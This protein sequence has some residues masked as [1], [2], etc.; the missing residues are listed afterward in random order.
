MRDRFIISESDRQSILSMY[1]LLTEEERDYTF[2]GRILG[3]DGDYSIGARVSIVGE[4]KEFV[5]G[6]TTD[7]NGSY[8]LNVKL[9]NTKI[10]YII[11]KATKETDIEEKIVNMD[12]FVQTINLNFVKSKQREEVKVTTTRSVR[13]L[14]NVKDTEGNEITDYNL[15]VKSKGQEIFKA[16]VKEKNQELVFL[17]GGTEINTKP[18]NYEEIKK[19]NDLIEINNSGKIE[20]LIQ[21]SG[22]VPSDKKIKYDGY[23]CNINMGSK[24]DES[25]NH[26]FVKTDGY[27]VNIIPNKKQNDINIVI[28]KIQTSIELTLIDQFKEIVST[29]NVNIKSKDGSINETLTTDTNG[30]LI[31]DANNWPSNTDYFIVA[32]KEGYQKQFYNFNLES[33]KI[34]KVKVK[35]KLIK[36]K[37]DKPKEKKEVVSKKIE[38]KTLP[39][40][41]ATLEAYNDGIRK[42]FILV[43]MSTDDLTKKILR[44]LNS[45]YNRDNVNTIN[46]QYYP[47]YYNVDSSDSKGYVS[48][49][50]ILKVNTY[51]YVAVVNIIDD[52]RRRKVDMNL[53]VDKIYRSISDLENLDNLL[54][55]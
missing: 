43:G 17:S 26:T 54:V 22:Y 52:P 4:N 42:L 34:N 39:L 37:T 44:N 28:S 48:L 2:K 33:N 3:S 31:I 47:L 24:K 25:G 6:V 53:N 9:D 55:V 16:T 49:N 13:F 7:T 38:F 50:S 5:G 8:T 29:A 14:L 30:V 41:D 46:N 15:S 32:E 10:Y 51:P 23:N 21:K 20:F 40:Y 35:I 18:V 36:P 1:G 45:K 12:K 27:R 11:V 19:N